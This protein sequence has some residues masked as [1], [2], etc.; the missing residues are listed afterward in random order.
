MR[1]LASFPAIFFAVLLTGQALAQELVPSI[2]DAYT[3]YQAGDFTA[4]H[5]IWLHHA[6]RGNPTAQFFVGE[7]HRMGHGM[8]QDFGEAAMWYRLAAEQGLGPALTKLGEM[9]SLGLGVPQ[10]HFEAARLFRLAI[11][12]SHSGGYAGLGGLYFS[13]RG[14]P[15]N[16]AEA[17]RLNRIAAQLG[18][19]SGHV[20]LGLM[21]MLGRGV[22]EDVVLSHMWFNI[23]AAN[24]R[25]TAWRDTVAA[26]MSPA[27]VAEAQV[28]ARACMASNYQDCE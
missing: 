16:F 15:Q 23:A 19:S 13:G 4:A 18:D 9:H 11:E 14:V 12:Q 6:A 20:N 2:E 25:D 26:E 5:D 17:L 22:P 3:A 28:R 24:G 8:P 27:Q 1:H 10:D 7:L 21:Y